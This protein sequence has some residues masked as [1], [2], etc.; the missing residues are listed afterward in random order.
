MTTN[1]QL[2]A[3]RDQ[4]VL[5]RQCLWPLSVLLQASCSDDETE[6]DDDGSL[7]D[8]LRANRPCRVRKLVW[9]ND[10]LELVAL[11]VD[12]YKSKVD[13]S[14]PGH[15]PGQRG[16]RPR[17]RIRGNDQPLSRIEAPVG[18]PVD[19]Y[20]VEWLGTLS[21]VQRA[22]LEIHPEPVL[23]QFISLLADY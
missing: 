21:A 17:Q 12:K 5:S 23:E 8:V 6:S 20:S 1:S 9:R 15:S 10:A 11:L 19:C 13:E 14:I 7:N 22:Q 18:L 4:T 16:R 3:L 2:K